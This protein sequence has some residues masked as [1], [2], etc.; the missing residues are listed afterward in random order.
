MYYPD[1]YYKDIIQEIILHCAPFK[2]YHTFTLPD[3]NELLISSY[4]HIS[5]QA[6]PSKS[7]ST[8]NQLESKEQENQTGEMSGVTSPAAAG[9]NKEEIS[10]SHER[11]E[12]CEILFQ[13]WRY[14]EAQ[15]LFESGFS[16]YLQ[17]NLIGL[18]GLIIQTYQK[19]DG[20][21]NKHDIVLSGGNI[22]LPGIV[23][24]LKFEL[25]N[26]H[27]HGHTNFRGGVPNIT[28]PI[29]VLIKGPFN[30]HPFFLCRALFLF[31][32]FL[33]FFYIHSQPIFYFNFFRNFRKF[34]IPLL[35]QILWLYERLTYSEILNLESFLE[36]F[37][38]CK[39]MASRMKIV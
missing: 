39:F 16:S 4:T 11:F 17:K 22:L 12:P 9:G 32:S 36:I 3:K 6:N 8:L 28:V 21:A 31:L 27:K 19:C 38:K 34:F 14:Y 1:Y 18:D 29:N 5:N 35:K 7:S 13:P 23:E 15:S 24:R 25:K 33:Y 10:L 37:Q 30:E 26:K 20:I 2:A